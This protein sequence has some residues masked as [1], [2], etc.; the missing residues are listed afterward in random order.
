MHAGG[1]LRDVAKAFA[2]MHYEI[3]LAKLHFHGIQ[4]GSDDW[5]KSCLGDRKLK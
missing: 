4:G 1:I 3:L 2:R 5:F